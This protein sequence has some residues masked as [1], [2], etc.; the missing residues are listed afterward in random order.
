MNEIAM[1]R[2]RRRGRL[3]RMD[4]ETEAE[5]GSADPLCTSMDLG[6]IDIKAF[7]L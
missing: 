1:T 4:S 6:R 2:C 7:S 5:S 3:A